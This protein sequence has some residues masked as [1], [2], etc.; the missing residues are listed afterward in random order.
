V[1]LVSLRGI[2]DLPNVGILTLIEINRSIKLIAI[3]ERFC[4]LL[5]HQTE[6]PVA[7]FSLLT[8]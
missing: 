1:A 8:L 6:V 3:D 4:L 5:V 7:P 2:S